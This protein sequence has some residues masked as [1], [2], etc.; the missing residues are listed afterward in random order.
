MLKFRKNHFK[1]VFV[2]VFNL[3]LLFFL[4]SVKNYYKMAR[5]LTLILSQTIAIVIITIYMFWHPPVN[6]SAKPLIFKSLM[7]VTAWYKKSQWCKGL[8]SSLQ[9]PANVKDIHAPHAY[10]SP[11]QTLFRW[12]AIFISLVVFFHFRTPQGPKKIRSCSNFRESGWFYA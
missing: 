12:P 3:Y 9:G 5:V 6:L 10:N 1:Y 7:Y 2:F 8:I 11:L 4:A